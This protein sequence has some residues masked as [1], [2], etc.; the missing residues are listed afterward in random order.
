MSVGQRVRLRA[1][2]GLQ[3]GSTAWFT[4][5]M[6]AFESTASR[7]A[8]CAPLAPDNADSGRGFLPLELVDFSVELVDLITQN[9]EHLALQIKF[10]PSHHIHA[11]QTG[12]EG[13]A[14]VLLQIFAGAAGEH[15]LELCGEFIKGHGK[16]L[17]N[18]LSTIFCSARPNSE[19]SMLLRSK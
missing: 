3:F 8:K 9:R 19:R 2:G 14:Q 1:A 17:A 15:G 10:L 12:A 16:S 5:Q 7:E 11:C 18:S 4:Q 13:G 6:T